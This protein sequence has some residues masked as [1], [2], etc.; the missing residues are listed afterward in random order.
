MDSEKQYPSGEADPPPYTAQADTQQTGGAPGGRSG[1]GGS[2]S[3]N[4][5][6]IK[7]PPGLLMIINFCLL[8]LCWCI[9]AGWRDAVHSIVASDYSGESG[10]YLAATVIPWL[11]FM[12]FFVIMVLNI[13]T[14]LTFINFP[15]TIMGNCVFWAVLLLISSS[16]VA[17]KARKMRG[18]YTSYCD[19]WECGHLEACTA[20]GFF[21]V[22]GM[23]IQAFLHFREWRNP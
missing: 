4:I 7:T 11:F 13:H 3:F 2:I 8:F 21:A 19:V 5:G 23:G 1:G 17:D 18:K 9:M 12:V 16:I 14:K 20:F 15:L 6:F 10:F 22:V